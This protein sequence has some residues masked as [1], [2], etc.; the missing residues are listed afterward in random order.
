VSSDGSTV[1]GDAADSTGQRRA[2]EWTAATGMK[3]LSSLSASGIGSGSYFVY[4]NAISGDAHH[5]VGWG[6]NRSKSRYE[7]YSTN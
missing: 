5:V 7:A 3:S 1:V 2:F 4:A 6:Y